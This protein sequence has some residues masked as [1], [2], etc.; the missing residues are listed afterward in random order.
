VDYVDCMD[1]NGL[2]GLRG[3]LW[4]GFDVDGRGIGLRDKAA[5]DCELTNLLL[6]VWGH[7]F[8]DALLHAGG[9]AVDQR[10]SVRMEPTLDPQCCRFGSKFSVFVSF[11]IGKIVEE[12]LARIHLAPAT[13]FHIPTSQF[14]M[15]IGGQISGLSI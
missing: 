7:C 3:L 9:D 5:G 13:T 2:R 12:A 6:E 14:A 11:G 8:G 4:G 10:L 15:T 1:C